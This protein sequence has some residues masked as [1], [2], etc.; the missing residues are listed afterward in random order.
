MYPIFT[1]SD[2][3]RKT[4]IKNLH[5]LCN[6]IK[7]SIQRVKKGYCD[8]DVGDINCWFFNVF[9]DMLNEFGKMDSDKN[10]IGFPA[11]F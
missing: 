3:S 7:W 11:F 2:Y 4:P 9:P 1:K 6:Q 10:V 5:L 8:W